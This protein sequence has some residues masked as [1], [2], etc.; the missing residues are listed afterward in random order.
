MS[1]EECPVVGQEVEQRLDERGERRFA[2]PAE[3]EGSERDPQLTGG[4]KGVEARDDPQHGRGQ[5]MALRRKLL[6]PGAPHGHQGELGGDE[7]AVGQ[8]QQ[9]DGQQSAGDVETGWIV[10]GCGVRPQLAPATIL[11]PSTGLRF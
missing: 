4:E 8:D 3:A 9:D 1:A 7:K 2:N 5:R 10:H 6:D 11:H